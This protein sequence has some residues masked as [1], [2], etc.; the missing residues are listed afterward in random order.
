MISEKYILAVFMIVLLPLLSPLEAG[1]TRDAEY[2]LKAA[3]FAK[4][5]PFVQFQSDSNEAKLRPLEVAVLGKD[6]F[7][8]KLDQVLSSAGPCKRGVV[9]ERIPT[10]RLMR[11]SG[12]TFDAVF[13]NLKDA[14]ELQEALK[15]FSE[16]CTLTVG[17]TGTFCRSGGMISLLKTRNRIQFEINRTVAERAGVKISSKLL[18]LATVVESDISMEE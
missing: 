7:G 2:D 3:F 4:L 13:I 15:L 14:T 8:V 5:L 10:V 17:D 6:S 1:L 11:V 12:K 16:D 9:V 18:A